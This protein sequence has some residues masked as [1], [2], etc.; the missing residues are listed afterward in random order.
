VK[1]FWTETINKEERV[2]IQKH[3]NVIVAKNP[4]LKI[5]FE[6]ITTVLAPIEVKILLVADC[7]YAEF[8]TRRL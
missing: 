7:A 8:A 3:L 6:Q 5:K 1:V 2:E 4:V